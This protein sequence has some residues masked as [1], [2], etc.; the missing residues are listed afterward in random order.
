MEYRHFNHQIKNMNMNTNDNQ[1]RILNDLILINNDRVVGYQKAIDQLK[2]E[3]ADLKVHFQEKVNQ[4]T[5]LKSELTK[6][7][8]A[9]GNEVEAGTTNAGK[10]YRVW[11]DVKA[12][13]GGADRK[14]ILDNCEVGESAALLAYK[15]AL[16]S[17]EL[18]E[19]AYT[20]VTSHNA[21]LK[22]AHDKITS[23]KEA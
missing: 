16:S 19:E 13:F 2:D 21:E 11:M 9:T 20:L 4:S 1:A 3:N 10:V 23:L 8:L 7:V 18:S 22:V 12:F 14:A 6:K 5:R 15:R 17:E